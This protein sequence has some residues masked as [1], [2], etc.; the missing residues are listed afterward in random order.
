MPMIISR[1]PLDMPDLDRA[2]IKQA[3]NTALAPTD[4]SIPAVIRHSSIPTARKAL[5]AVCFR[6]LIRLE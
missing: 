1:M 5:K 4:R 3:Q 6:I 2:P